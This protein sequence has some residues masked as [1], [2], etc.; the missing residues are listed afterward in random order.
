MRLIS[1]ALLLV[2]CGSFLTSNALPI[3]E[4]SLE[5][6]SGAVS[7]TQARESFSGQGVKRGLPPKSAVKVSAE[8]AS[9]KRC[10]GTA[11]AKC[12]NKVKK[13]EL[14]GLLRR[15]DDSSSAAY[16]KAVGDL[17]TA[18]DSLKIS[19][20]LLGGT[21]C[22]ALGSPRTTQDIDMVAH[23]ASAPGTE[24]DLLEKALG[25]RLVM[26]VDQYGC[27]EV[28][29]DGIEVDI[30][31]PQVWPQRPQYMTFIGAPYEVVTPQTKQKVHVPH[32]KLLLKEKEQ[33]Y[34]DRKNSSKGP[35]DKAD[36]AFL[37]GYIKEKL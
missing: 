13:R 33:S 10:S 17:G 6:R 14:G 31:D 19:Y 23:S 8:G 36:V 29:M 9:P 3:D 22:A 11:C 4:A 16:W 7:V 34:E 35:N 2:T 26:K 37:T 12:N 27:P 1:V 25:G 32:P 28:T 15:A 18:C 5:Y 20:V 24:V 21:A 30:F